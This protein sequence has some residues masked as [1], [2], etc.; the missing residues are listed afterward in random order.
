MNQISNQ[1]K[2]Q[3]PSQTNVVTRGKSKGIGA[4]NLDKKEPKHGINIQSKNP[5]SGLGYLNNGVGAASRND[6]K[7]EIKK[8]GIE[9]K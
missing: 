7:P 8:S 4:N 2:V 1:A 6:K 9:K 3:P 5:S